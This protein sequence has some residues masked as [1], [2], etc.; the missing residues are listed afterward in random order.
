MGKM[1]VK[2][3]SGIEYEL[4]EASG[5]GYAACIYDADVRG[6]VKVDELT[7]DLAVRVGLPVAEFDRDDMWAVADWLTDSICSVSLDGESGSNMGMDL[8]FGFAHGS[9]YLADPGWWNPSLTR[10]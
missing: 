5:E 6:Q 1:V 7:W 2:L 3:T 4:E 10:V 8:A 9:L